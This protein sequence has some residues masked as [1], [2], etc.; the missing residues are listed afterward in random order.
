MELGAGQH[1]SGPAVGD[2]GNERAFN[3]PSSIY[4]FAVKRLHAATSPA[5]LAASLIFPATFPVIQGYNRQQF[6]S[7]G[8]FFKARSLSHDTQIHFSDL[9][10]AF[11]AEHF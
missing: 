1:G 7:S 11:S 9:G 4:Y 6:T 3:P 5:E 2:L 10:R 8:K